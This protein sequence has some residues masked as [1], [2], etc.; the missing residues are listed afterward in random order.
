M[1]TWQTNVWGMDLEYLNAQADKLQALEK[2]LK[3][4]EKNLFATNRL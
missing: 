4:N 2:L 1:Y 3:Q